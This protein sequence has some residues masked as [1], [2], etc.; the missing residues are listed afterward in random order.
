ME[1]CD[2]PYTCEAAIWHSTPSKPP[3]MW[4]IL[5]WKC[6]GPEDVSKHS[7]LKQYLLKGIDENLTSNETLQG[8]LLA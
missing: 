4:G 2:S 7:L 3:R 1:A 8:A 6:L 5:F